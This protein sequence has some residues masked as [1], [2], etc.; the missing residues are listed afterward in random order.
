[1]FKRSAFV[2]LL[3]L[4]LFALPGRAQL[5]YP[6]KAG[7]EVQCGISIVSPKF[8]L[9]GICMLV[10]DSD[11]IK[12]AVLNEFGVT[13]IDFVYRP[14][15]DKVELSHVYA[16]L[17]KWYIRDVMAADVKSL[18]KAFRQGS[19]GYRDEKYNITFNLTP[20]SNIEEDDS[21]EPIIQD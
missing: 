15:T 4:L 12:G 16:K 21:E 7:R 17:D 18:L 20:L 11:T 8:N 1:M 13:F 10:N 14:E 5:S 2:S 19:T 6:D 3:A 9:S